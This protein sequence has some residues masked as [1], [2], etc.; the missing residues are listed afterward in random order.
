MLKNQLQDRILPFLFRENH[1]FFSP[2]HLPAFSWLYPSITPEDLSHLW[3]R[4]LLS[5][6]S[7]SVDRTV[8]ISAG[9]KEF[10]S[11]LTKKTEARHY[12]KKAIILL[13]SFNTVAGT[14]FHWP[15]IF[16]QTSWL[17]LLAVSRAAICWGASPSAPGED[18]FT[19]FFLE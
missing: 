8:P 6:V 9:R 16:L 5:L 17:K 3:T 1:N 14:I 7:G 12:T 10:I 4:L 2:V 13:Q 18:C 11:F 19:W 15:H